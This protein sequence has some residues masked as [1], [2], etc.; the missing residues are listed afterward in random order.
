[1]LCYNLCLVLLQV[2]KCFVPVQ[3]FWASPKIWLHLEPLQ[4]LFCR[5]KNQFYWMHI[6]FL[7][8]T[9]CLWLPQYV[10]KFLVWH[11]KTWTSPK[12]FGT[13][14]R[15]RHMSSNKVASKPQNSLV[16]PTDMIIWVAMFG[17]EHVL[18]YRLMY[19]HSTTLVHGM[20][21]RHPRHYSS[22]TSR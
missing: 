18:L 8:A 21:R 16:A 19:L 13:C 15:T 12:H 10:N 3:I 1:M 11:K 14:K 2:P 7:S 4:K 17:L 22:P 20:L 5:H 6:I 9:K